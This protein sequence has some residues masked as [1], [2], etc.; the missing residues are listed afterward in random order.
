[1]TWKVDQKTVDRLSA[2]IDA[3]NDRKLPTKLRGQHSAMRSETDIINV[4]RLKTLYIE[5]FQRTYV[6]PNG[7]NSTRRSV[8]ML[9]SGRQR[10][11][12]H[13]HEL[14]R[15]NLIVPFGFQMFGLKWVKGLIDWKILRMYFLFVTVN[16]KDSL[17][18]HHLKESLIFIL[19]I[20]LLLL[21]RLQ[22]LVVLV[23]VWLEG[24]L[25]P[26]AQA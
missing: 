26:S 11:R 15:Y 2:V 20:F 8:V 22:G 5:Y 1:A 21:S 18:I 14:F 12:K 4:N 24:L 25:C 9:L 16:Q 19:C 6:L 10:C 3:S 17:N 13:G 23:I 7:L